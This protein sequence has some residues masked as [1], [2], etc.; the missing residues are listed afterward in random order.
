MAETEIVNS[1][2]EGTCRGCLEAIG[3]DGHLDRKHGISKPRGQES[4][5][6]ILPP[7]SPLRPRPSSVLEEERGEGGEGRKR[8]R[9]RLSELLEGSIGSS[10]LLSHPPRRFT[11]MIANSPQ[12]LLAPAPESVPVLRTPSFSSL[13][14]LLEALGSTPD[15]HS[16]LGVVDEFEDEFE[17]ERESDHFNETLAA[18]LA[19]SYTGLDTDSVDIDTI[20]C[21]PTPTLE[22]TYSH[23]P[24]PRDKE[25]PL[26]PS[27][28]P[29][30]LPIKLTPPMSSHQ[31]DSQ[32]HTPALTKRHHALLELLT[33][34]RAY[35]SDLALIRDVYMRLASGESFSRPCFI[36][37]HLSFQV[38]L[39]LSVS[40][41]HAQSRVQE[42]QTLAQT[43]L[44]QVPVPL[45]PGEHARPHHLAQ[46][47]PYPPPTYP[48]P[49]FAPHR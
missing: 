16:V 18:T 33:S 42:F 30:S 9:F 31:D 22:F 43:H 41:A 44:A 1:E 10:H 45:H 49:A 46:S 19:H 39:H 25:L 36:L 11:I 38:T 48:L 34:E 24:S 28:L 8:R 21:G 6:P 32:P 2:G 26:P 13:S 47:A 35:A 29:L 17:R 20:N 40:L 7:R 4:T 23:L 15:L 27:T 5:P 14:Q 37:I 3:N 12:N